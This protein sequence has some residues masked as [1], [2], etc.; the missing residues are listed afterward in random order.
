M[1]TISGKLGFTEFLAMVGEILDTNASY[2]IVSAENL[3]KE[4]F[5]ELYNEGTSNLT[6]RYNS[7]KN[8]LASSIADIKTL[9]EKE[10]KLLKSLENSKFDLN[11][12]T[13]A[14]KEDGYGITSISNC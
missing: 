2:E 9:S 5:E 14:L 13:L 8:S 4:E 1:V 11:M 7:F 3:L 10:N 12:L 6:M